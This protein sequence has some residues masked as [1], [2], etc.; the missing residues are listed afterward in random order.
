MPSKKFEIL[1]GLDTNGPAIFSNTV[2]ITGNVDIDS[3]TLFVDVSSSRVGVNKIPTQ[4][5]IDVDGDVYATNFHGDG[6]NL[7]NAG[8]SSLDELSDVSVSGVQDGQYLS[9]NSSTGQWVAAGIS[10]EGS[11]PADGSVSLTSFASGLTPVQLVDI[12]PDI[13]SPDRFEGEIV[14]LTTNGNLYRFT[15]GDWT[16]AVPLNSVTGAGALAALNTIG[17]DQIDQQAITNAK[18]AVDAIRENVI[19]A[20]AITEIKIANGSISTP[21]IEA[22]AITANQIASGAIIAEKIQ[23]GAVTANAILANTITGNKIA[24]G[25]I[26]ADKIATGAITAGKISAGAVTADKILSNSITA[27]QIK[28]GAIGVSELAAG[29]VTANAIA[30]GALQAD[31]ITGDISEHWPF[32]I[33][34]GMAGASMG[35]LSPSKDTLDVSIP[36]PSGG[37]EKQPYIQG[38]VI[39]D[40]NNSTTDFLLE[41]RLLSGKSYNYTLTGYSRDTPAPYGTGSTVYGIYAGNQTQDIC[42]GGLWETSAGD[43]KSVFGI[44]YDESANETYILYNDDDGGLNNNATWTLTPSTIT[45]GDSNLLFPTFGDDSGGRQKTVPFFGILPRSNVATTFRL[46][47]SGSGF[48]RGITGHVGYLR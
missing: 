4:G 2:S 30:V 8:V 36:A 34:T 15:G 43:N 9:Y 35:T 42:L 26:D 18:I 24:A 48:L 14:F 1:D 40:T 13:S 25:A 11:I 44:F 3:D 39:V 22:G 16:N 20:G 6:S 47:W 37:V 5:A 31:K 10:D 29:A 19:Q 32:G 23:A 12:L 46:C 33:G 17:S 21:K 41:I 28:A 38:A 27:G 7:T 45:T